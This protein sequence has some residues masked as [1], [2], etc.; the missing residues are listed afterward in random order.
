MG[1]VPP[2]TALCLLLSLNLLATAT[3]AAE[4]R[5][6]KSST[7][8]ILWAT[9]NGDS[10]IL[11]VIDPNEDNVAGGDASDF[12]GGFS[13]LEGMLQWAIG[14]SDVEKLKEKANNV[15]RSSPAEL[16]Q[17]QLKLKEL[18]EKL[19]M[20]SDAELMKVAIDDLSNYSISIEDRQRALNELLILVEDIDNAND[21]DKLGGLVAVIRELDNSEPEIRITSAWILGT[22]SQNNAPVQNQVLSLG[23]LVR[24][25]SMAKS[26]SIEEAIKALFAI[27][28]LI[29]NNERGQ[30][31][32]YSESGH[33]ILQDIMSNIASDIK[34][35]KKAAILVADLADYQKHNAQTGMITKHSPINDRHF[36]KSLVDLT[37]SNNLGLQE[38]ALLAVKSLLEL[39]STDAFDFRDFCGFEEVLERIREQLEEKMKENGA[40]AEELESLRREIQTIFRRKLDET[41]PESLAASGLEIRDQSVC[42]FS[43][44][45]RNGGIY[46][47]PPPAL[48]SSSPLPTS[49]LHIFF[50]L[51][52]LKRVS[53]CQPAAGEK[54]C[55]EI[56]RRSRVRR[57]E[58][59]DDDTY[60]NMCDSPEFASQ[61][62]CR[63]SARVC[64]DWA[65]D[66][67]TSAA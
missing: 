5:V 18:M 24:L 50:E 63:K 10:D 29:R 60:I 16:K 67:V 43:T 34:L 48:R 21:L 47:C 25:M 9:A 38:K 26:S 23:V 19:K 41:K 2:A 49:N 36:L 1:S 6:N 17:R 56:C 64:L 13:S 31:L 58:L 12:T 35:Q 61:E 33:L 3:A 55:L 54:M 39:P 4:S 57:E 7:G 40:Y 52:G 30:E 22:A 32:F 14:H 27:S 62:S 53:C 59:F 20:P 28:S 15:Q 37:S 11:A 45:R 42:S 44:L 51:S 65:G 66:C 46:F 8:G